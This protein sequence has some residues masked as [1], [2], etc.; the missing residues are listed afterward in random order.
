[1][2]RG[3]ALGAWTTAIPPACPNA[4]SPVSDTMKL[5]L[6]FRIEGKRM[7]RIEAD[8]G[9]DRE[10]LLGEVARDPRVLRVAPF[11]AAKE[12]DPLALQRGK[13]GAVQQLVLLGDEG[14]RGGAD[15][16]EHPRSA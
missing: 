11:A 5:R 9:H 16:A 13:D 4:S 14:V 2:I 10:E 3:S 1:M 8:R 7:N 12:A 6:L 15:A